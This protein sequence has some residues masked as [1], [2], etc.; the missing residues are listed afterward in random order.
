MN[1]TTRI[2][3]VEQR[4]CDAVTMETITRVVPAATIAA[5]ID[6]IGV[7]ERRVRKLSADLEYQPANASALT[8][9]RYQL[10]VRVLA[11]LFRRVCQPLAQARTR[12]AFLFGLRLMA[13]GGTK[14]DV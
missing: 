6:E 2:V 10:G 3:G 14:G 5:V 1:F 9:R 11:R 8:Q 13:L 12:G 7:K 4:F